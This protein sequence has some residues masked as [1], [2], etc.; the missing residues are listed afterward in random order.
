[1]SHAVD[2]ARLVVGLLVHD[3]CQ[4]VGDLVVVFPIRH[5][6]LD[7]GLHRPDLVVCT[8]ML[9]S[10]ERADGCGVHRVRIGVGRG[11]HARGERGIVA[12]AVLGVQTQ[13]DVEH[14]RLFRRE[15]TI[16]TKHR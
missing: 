8:A 7:V 2:Q 14:A 10:L 4:V 11:H 16:G 9:L 15:L 5:M 13:H 3:L 6:L 12:A 1:M